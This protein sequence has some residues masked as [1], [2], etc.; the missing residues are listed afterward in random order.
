MAISFPSDE[1]VLRKLLDKLLT[2]PFITAQDDRR[3]GGS[4]RERSSQ[5]C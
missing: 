1:E 4:I 3:K 5:A 2:F